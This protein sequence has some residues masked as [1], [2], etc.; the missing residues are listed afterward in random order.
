MT[1]FI[2]NGINQIFKDQSSLK[3]NPAELKS[4]SIRLNEAIKELLQADKEERA[5]WE[6]AKQYLGPKMGLQLKEAFE[7]TDNE[8]Y[9]ALFLVSRYADSLNRISNV[10]DS[11]EDRI[12][13]AINSAESSNNN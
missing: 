5:A 4:L 8:F 9:S 3:V 1:D 2:T 11:A 12:M 7:K 13:K 10:W 6:L